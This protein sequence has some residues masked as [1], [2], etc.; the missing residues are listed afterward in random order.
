MPIDYSQPGYKE[1]FAN[2]GLTAF[3]AQAMEK[4]L[5]LL[6]AA[7]EC[8][9]A[10]KVSKS[11]LYKVFDRHDRKTLGR[12]IDALRKKIPIAQ[13]LDDD[14]NHALDKRNYVVHNF[15][16]DRWDNQRLITPEQ[17]SEELRPIRDLFDDV[18]NR[19]DDILGIVQRQFEVPNAKLDQQAKKML[20][21]Y[22]SSNKSV[23]RN[24]P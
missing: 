24:A 14:L 20:K 6:L 12:L 11:E 22:Q 5:F 8:L 9:E 3:G 10:R 1:M 17:M 4:T 16:L 13:N 15:F 2:Y 7:V 19:I 18:K 23:E 21:I